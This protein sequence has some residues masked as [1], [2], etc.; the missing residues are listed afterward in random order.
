MKPALARRIA[1][2]NKRITNRLTLP[3]APRLPGFGI[4]VHRGRHSGRKYETP[5]NVFRRLDGF[6]FA[7]TYGAQADW[8]QNVLAAGGC[9]LITRGRR[10]QLTAPKIVHDESRHLASFIARPMLRLLRAADFLRMRRTAPTMERSPP[11]HPAM[12]H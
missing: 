12:A 10:Y 3:L 7:L 9:E 4:V 1:R 6:T 2:F 5:V 8:V 11:R